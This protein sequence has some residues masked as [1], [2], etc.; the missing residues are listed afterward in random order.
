[1][2]TASTGS[3]RVSLCVTHLLA[4]HREGERVID[5]LE[6]LLNE[7]PTDGCWSPDRAATFSELSRFFNE[8]A[9]GHVQKE[10]DILFPALEAYLPRD[11]GP[12]AVLR[13][14]HKELTGLF[15][16][17]VELGTVLS[18]ARGDVLVCAEFEGTGRRLI[19]AFRDHVYKEDRI[20]YPMVSRFLSA[21]R[22]T[23]LVEQM[24]GVAVNSAKAMG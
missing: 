7:P 22:D 13:G 12:L 4:D 10:E 6:Y 17:L 19:Q 20:L 18:S 5:R 11:I 3:P 1:M 16:R 15:R 8:R 2:N 23:H 9:M 24:T 14:E 21:E